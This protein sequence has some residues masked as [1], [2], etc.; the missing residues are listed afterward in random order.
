LTGNL[1]TR[2]LVLRPWEEADA[3]LLGRMASDPIVVRYIGD[4]KPWAADRVDEVGHAM[5]RHWHEHDF[6]WRVVVQNETDQAVGFAA[7]NYLGD[8]TAGLDPREFEIGWWL[9]PAV[10]RRGFAT[11]AARA[12]CGEAFGR[13]RAPSLVARLQP[14]NRA[15]AAVATKLGMRHEF[16]TTGRFGEPV[17]VYRLDGG[18][19][20]SQGGPG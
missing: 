15:S 4:G 7:L 10:W 6:G 17:A 16:D 12:V 5:T 1:E 2:R 13:L 19:S 20:L 9:L 14:K 3:E 8:G 18:A 11:E